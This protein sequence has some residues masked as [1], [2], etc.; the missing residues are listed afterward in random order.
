MLDALHFGALA[1][2]HI[3][4][5]VVEVSPVRGLPADYPIS[6]FFSLS[7]L[8]LFHPCVVVYRALRDFQQFKGFHLPVSKQAGFFRNHFS[9]P[10]SN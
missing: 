5:M 4:V 10:G 6:I 7:H 1:P 8:G 9:E 2:T 3:S